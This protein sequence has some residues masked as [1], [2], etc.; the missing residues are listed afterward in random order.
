MIP[1][2]AEICWSVGRPPSAVVN[3]SISAGRATNGKSPISRP[4]NSQP[5]SAAVRAIHLPNVVIEE[6]CMVSRGL[7]VRVLPDLARRVRP[8]SWFR[9]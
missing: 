1:S 4:S 6:V 8:S 7:P 5:R 9:S 2:H 3:K